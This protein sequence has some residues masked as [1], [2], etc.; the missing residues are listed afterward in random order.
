MLD[1][2][3]SPKFKKDLK[4][5]GRR[6][7]DIAKM[8]YPVAILLSGQPLP[9]VYEDHSLKGE[10]AGYKDFHVEPDWVVIYIA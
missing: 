10:W 1:F 9:P 4:H 5:V 8:F 7:R 2:A 3:Y 6:G